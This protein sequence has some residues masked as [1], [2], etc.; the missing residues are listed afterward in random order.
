M[1]GVGN[2]LDKEKVEKMASTEYDTVLVDNYNTL[3]DEYRRNTIFD[4]FCG[5]HLSYSVSF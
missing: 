5:S 2:Q 1:V 4:Q 3:A